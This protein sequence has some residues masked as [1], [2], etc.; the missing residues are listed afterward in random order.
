MRNRRRKILL[1][2]FLQ[3]QFGL[4]S[5][6][7]FSVALVYILYTLWIRVRYILLET[8]VD[9]DALLHVREQG[10]E[11]SLNV[12]LALV[13]FTFCNMLVSTVLTFR[14]VG[15][16]IAFRRHLRALIAGDY[17]VRTKLRRNDAFREVARDLNK[18]SAVLEARDKGVEAQEL[19]DQDSTIDSGEDSYE[20]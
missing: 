8:G 5:V 9:Q 16:T 2:P 4:Y 13:F 20:E 1:K 3:L 6:L 14:L 19:I 17:N 10:L 11:A 15:P 18:L 12:F 7:P